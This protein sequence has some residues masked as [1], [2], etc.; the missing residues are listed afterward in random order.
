[1]AELE[2]KYTST[3]STDLKSYC[4]QFFLDRQNEALKASHLE[5]HVYC[6]I[7]ITIGFSILM[8]NKTPQIL[9]SNCSRSHI[10]KDI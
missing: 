4:F 8:L 10:Y 1:M 9:V 2:T 5:M 3:S 7:I 6:K